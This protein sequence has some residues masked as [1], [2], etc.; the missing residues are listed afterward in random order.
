MADDEIQPGQRRWGWV[1]RAFDPGTSVVFARHA[2]PEQVIRG[3]RLDPTAGTMMTWQQAA[4]MD[5]GVVRDP[6]GNKLPYPFLR[7]GRYGDW[8]FAVDPSYLAL[9]SSIRGHQVL[10]TLSA[11]SEAVEVLWTPKPNESVQYYAD[12]EWVMTFE[13]YRAWDRGP[14]RDR[15]V[16]E[17]RQ[18]GLH[19]EPPSEAARRAEH[20][21]FDVLIAAL[22]MLTIALGIGLTEDLI[23]GPLLT[24]PI[25]AWLAASM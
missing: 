23:A 21:H 19:T 4:R 16:N 17:M 25:P 1:R 18:V 8:A 14:T 11:R 12:G 10:A 13:P 15:F 20:H 2:T 5:W 7:V 24:V 3:F 9:N 22:E 6:S